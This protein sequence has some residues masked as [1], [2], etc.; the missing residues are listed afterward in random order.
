MPVALALV[1]TLLAPSD[2]GAT[3]VSATQLRSLAARAA[4]NPA[5]L[6][7]LRAVDEVDGLPVDIAGALEG[8]SPLELER[9]LEALSISPD[10][11][12]EPEPEDARALAKEI[13]GERRFQQAEAPRP[14]QGALEWLGE[15]LSPLGSALRTAFEWLAGR[16]PGGDSAVAAAI[17]ILAVGL[18][19]IVALRMASR[20]RGSDDGSKQRTASPEHPDPRAL[21]RAA[22]EAERRGDLDRAVRLRF[23]AGLAAL[24][25]ARAIDLSASLT[26]GEVAALLESPSFDQVSK[27]FDEVAYGGKRPAPAEVCGYKR[28]WTRVLAEAGPR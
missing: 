15:R 4:S 27:T 5:A 3:E 26:S 13:L 17:G 28:R 20:R 21:E 6:S 25:E 11:P 24:D 8:A 23:R 16:V 12:S 2:A 10:G 18:A 19:A 9:R 22:D 14:F 7:A 1:G